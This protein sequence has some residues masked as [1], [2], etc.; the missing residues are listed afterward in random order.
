MIHVINRGRLLLPGALLASALACQVAANAAAIPVTTRTLNNGQLILEDVPEIPERLVSRLNQY[1]DVRSAQQVDW[2]DGGGGMYIVT[3]FSDL[4]QIHRVDYPGGAR[5]QL[6]FFTE[7]VGEVLRQPHGALLAL[8]LDEGGSEFSQVFLYD[9]KT[10]VATLVSDGKSRNSRL[11]WD[12]SGS[13]LACQST[14]R[15]GTNNDIWL[16][17]VGRAESTR[18]VLEVSDENWWGPVDFSVDGRYLL[19]QQ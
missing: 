12:K 1:Q 9:P 7:P 19:V 17:D 6:T 3:R 18:P 14:R 15:N 11:V 13:R 5:H 4:N 8:T 16:M 10:A 2:V